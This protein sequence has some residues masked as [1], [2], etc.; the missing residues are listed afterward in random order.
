[1]SGNEINLTLNAKY[2][3]DCLPIIENNLVELKINEKNRPLLIKGV[4]NDFQYIVMPI[5]R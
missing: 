1:M 3:L 2:L 5:N 4:E